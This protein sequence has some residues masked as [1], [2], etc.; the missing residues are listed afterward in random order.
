MKTFQHAAVAALSLLALPGLQAGRADEKKVELREPINLPHIGLRIALPADLALQPTH[1]QRTVLAGRTVVDGQWK[2]GL[3]L[4]VLPLP[5]EKPLPGAK[6]LAERAA[7]AQT[8]PEGFETVIPVS[9]GEATVAGRKGWRITRKLSGPKGSLVE[10]ATVWGTALPKTKL[11]LLYFLLWRQMGTSVEAAVAKVDAVCAA[12]RPVPIRA[13]SEIDLPAL[14]GPVAMKG[15]RFS[16]PVPAGWFIADLGRKEGSDVVVRIRVVD[17]FRR[18]F[19]PNVNV[20]VVRSKGKGRTDY[21]N[22]EVFGRIL[23]SYREV[24]ATRTGWK[25]VSHRKAKLGGQ[26]C[27][28]FVSHVTVSGHPVLLITRQALHAGNIYTLT[29]GWHAAHPKPAAAAMEKLAAGL[30][31]LPPPAGPKA[32]PDKPARPEP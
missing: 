31:F 19:L 13:P 22:P 26:A 4:M 27:L 1:A 2:A 24:L 20:T 14:L 15:E 30:K 7:G 29:L 21:D 8:K 5:V 9:A 18:A 16:L 28:E 6:D 32:P 10:V 12:V 17:F 11:K 3:L 25:E 23:A